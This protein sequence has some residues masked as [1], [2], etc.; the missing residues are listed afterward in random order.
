MKADLQFDFVVSRDDNTMTI[1]KEFAAKRQLV[2]DCHVKSDLLE[3]W[4]APKPFTM[5]TKSMD[6]S[7]GGHWHYAMIGPDGQEHWGRMDYKTISPI[8]QYTALDGFCDETGAL[9]AELPRSEWQVTFMDV[10]GTDVPGTDGNRHT[11]VQTVIAFGS[12]AALEKVMAMGMKEGLLS[13]LERL[14]ELLL[15]FGHEGNSR[16]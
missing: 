14:D 7:E 3:Q 6:F 12:S 1:Q 8:D 15:T 11:R 4:F 16:S 13:A 5:K 2:W 9:N 10:P